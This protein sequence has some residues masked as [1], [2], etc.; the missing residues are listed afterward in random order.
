MPLTSVRDPLEALVLDEDAA[1][2]LSGLLDSMKAM[3]SETAKLLI[4]IWKW[5]RDNPQILT[6]P[7]Q[8]WPKGP[9]TSPVSVFQ[10]YAP[11]ARDFSASTVAS[12]HPVVMRR[13]FAASLDDA[14]RQQWDTFD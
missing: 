7:K 4:H 5:R 14:H 10:G 9:A 12:T 3:I 8:Q 1:Q 11:R 13:F 2:T 6:Q